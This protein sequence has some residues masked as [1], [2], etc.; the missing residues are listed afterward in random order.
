MHAGL[1]YVPWRMDISFKL[2][3]RVY[4]AAVLGSVL[5]Y[6]YET[7]S[8]RTERVRRLQ[9]FDYQCLYSIVGDG[10]SDVG[11]LVFGTRSGNITP[12]EA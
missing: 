4:S 6:G 5:W 10:L 7:W 12:Y 11:N 2:K 8:V 3:D 9:V 1:K